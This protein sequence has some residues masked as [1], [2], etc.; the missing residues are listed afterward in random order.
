MEVEKTYKSFKKYYR[1]CAVLDCLTIN[2]NAILNN[3]YSTSKNRGAV[4]NSTFGLQF[5]ITNKKTL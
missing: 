2:Q 4:Q 3:N 5:A 1:E